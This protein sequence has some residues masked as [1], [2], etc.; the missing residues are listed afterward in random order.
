MGA[1]AVRARSALHPWLGY[2]EQDIHFLRRTR[3]TGIQ[4]V[5]VPVYGGGI[6]Y[7]DRVVPI[8]RDALGD[9][10]VE[11]FDSQSIGRAVSA[12]PAPRSV[13]TGVIASAAG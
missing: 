5:A 8:R 6:D 2:G 12:S 11:V 3:D 4:R 13:A 7:R 1:H 10:H 9:V